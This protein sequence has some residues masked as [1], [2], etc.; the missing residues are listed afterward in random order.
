MSFHIK[1]GKKNQE[2]L[3]KLKN[4]GSDARLGIEKGFEELGSSL[5]RTGENQALNEP[6]F[7][8]EYS[9]K[10]N[11][12]KKLH[13]AS[14]AGQSPALLT[15]NYFENFKYENRGN[16]LEFGNDAEY[17]GYL[18]DGTDN[19]EP[20]PGVMNAVSSSVRNA[21]LYLEENIGQSLEL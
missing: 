11:G 14:S 13:R 19:M 9:F 10:I 21:R 6:K 3:D 4:L 18:E 15:G 12:V 1:A 17:S 7:G 2:I 20:R 5:V 16:E 8:R